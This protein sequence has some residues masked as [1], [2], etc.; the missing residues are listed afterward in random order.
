VFT[1]YLAND[2]GDLFLSF[3][4]FIKLELVYSSAFPHLAVGVFKLFNLFTGKDDRVL[5]STE[6]NGFLDLICETMG[7]RRFKLCIVDSQHS[8]TLSM[9]IGGF[10]QAFLSRE[11]TFQSENQNS[12]SK[13]DL[14]T[15]VEL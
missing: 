14:R 4:E 10:E 5:T 13:T 6:L 9:F 2:H 8:I 15:V 3:E 11:N 12:T 7:N 1:F